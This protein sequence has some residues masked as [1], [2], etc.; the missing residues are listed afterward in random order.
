MALPVTKAL[1][2][3]SCLARNW[4]AAASWTKVRAPPLRSPRPQ[5]N[6]SFGFARPA[7][8]ASQS[9]RRRGCSGRRRRASR[10]TLPSRY[11]STCQRPGAHRT[12]NGRQRKSRR[13]A[14][15][16]H[17]MSGRI[18]RASTSVNTDGSSSAMSVHLARVSSHTVTQRRAIWGPSSVVSAPFALRHPAPIRLHADPN[19]RR[20]RGPP[21]AGL[22]GRACQ[23]RDA[24][25]ASRAARETELK[26][27]E[28]EAD[29]RPWQ[30]L[31][32]GSEVHRPG[33]I[34][35][36]RGWARRSGSCRSR[37]NVPRR[38]GGSPQGRWQ[39]RSRTSPPRAPA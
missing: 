20:H 4:S 16:L 15:S 21:P 34:T 23:V 14:G 33:P 7:S 12:R 35:V 28:H 25:E 36:A 9:H 37:A 19:V 11:A 31:R 1:R 30:P 8:M 6:P 5:R 22:P 17:D 10:T 27:A 38:P 18:S 2:D 32:V 39:S 13:E 29:Q 3:T 26:S 24:T